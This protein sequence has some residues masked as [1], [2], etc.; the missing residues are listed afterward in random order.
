MVEKDK[1][2]EREEFIQVGFTAM[3][4]AEGGFL[5]PVPLFIK[6]T[7]E[8]TKA[9]IALHKDI[10]AVLADK[11]KQYQ[12]NIGKVKSEKRRKNKEQEDSK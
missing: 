5:P 3:R 12:Q 7:P 10:G 6:R 11:M 4:D 9:E 1:D 8:T 2:R